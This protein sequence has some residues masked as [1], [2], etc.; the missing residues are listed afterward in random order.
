MLDARHTDR[1]AEQ[2]ELLTVL[3]S[4]SFSRSPSLA[5]LLSYICN[6]YFQGEHLLLKEHTIAVEAL[7]RSAD[8]DQKKDSIVRVEAHRLRKRLRLYYETDGA[9]HEVR[10]DLPPGAYCPVF[11][12][13]TPASEPEP[14]I[15][16]V[17]ASRPAHHWW[18]AVACAFLII[19]V[20]LLLTDILPPAQAGVLHLP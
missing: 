5:Q 14:V 16:P 10:I 6:K 1:Q 9:D 3:D 17:P 18:L 15:P 4:R 11:I 12:H 13:S 2:A 7:G 8:F 19:S 20:I